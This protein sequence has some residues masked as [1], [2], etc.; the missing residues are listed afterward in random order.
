MMSIANSI[1]AVF[2]L[3]LATVLF[4][5]GREHDGLFFLGMTILYVLVFGVLRQRHKKDKESSN[6]EVSMD[7]QSALEREIF[8]RMDFTIDRKSDWAVIAMV[9]LA[10]EQNKNINN[11]AKVARRIV[12]KVLKI[13]PTEVVDEGSQAINKHLKALDYNYLKSE[14]NKVI[15]AECK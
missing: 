2:V 4:Y 1:I 7:L 8:N 15:A 13:L 9:R 12:D 6:K 5:S 3:I 10:T 14:F 11:P